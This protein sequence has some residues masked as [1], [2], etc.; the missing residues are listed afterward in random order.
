MGAQ[1]RFP[2]GPKPPKGRPRK[3]PKIENGGA[4]NTKGLP[5]RKHVKLGKGRVPKWCGI[6][7]KEGIIKALMNLLK[8]PP[9]VFHRLR[10]LI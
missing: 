1:K 2:C 6:K 4:R 10:N 8:E 5:K 3:G 9:P 7:G